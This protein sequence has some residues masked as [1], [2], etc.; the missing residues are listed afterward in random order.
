MTGR[1]ATPNV[2]DDV[3]GWT[4]TQPSTLAPQPTQ[5]PIASIRR[6][7]ATQMRAELNP[8]TV[9]EYS[10]D[11][12]GDWGNFPPVVVYY[13]GSDYWLADGFHRIAAYVSNPG[14]ELHTVPADIRTGT[15]RD[16][17]LHAAS[18]NSDHGLRRTRQDK[19]RSVETLLRDE[20]WAGWSDNEIAR[21][22]H[23]S[24]TFVGNIRRGLTF[25]VDSE[26]RAERTY[27]TK[28]GTTATMQTGNIGTK[29]ERQAPQPVSPEQRQ[30][31][32]AVPA[33]DLGEKLLVDYTDEDWKRL[34]E[35]RASEAAAAPAAPAG[36]PE[37]LAARGWE[38]R[39]IANSGRYWC[40]NANGPRATSVHDTAAAA[41]DEA[42]KTQIDVKAPESGVAIAYAKQRLYAAMAAMREAMVRLDGHHD[43]VAGGIKVLIDDLGR[44]VGELE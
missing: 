30:Y 43:E 24:P 17:I 10:M 12:D 31:S 6:D 9:T 1:K 25:H 3:L 18:A 34:A 21:R 19:I 13:D 2:L 20:E 32:A 15:R 8:A 26:T 22:C 7:G 37:D 36:M 33:A 28:H 29:A 42:R 41:I 27:T 5:L 23:V 16:A 35:R 14:R 39:Q 44:L 11:M 4:P 38:L 40:H